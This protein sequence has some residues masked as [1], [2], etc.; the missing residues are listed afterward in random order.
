MD[1]WV[2]TP[3]DEIE[4]EV[5]WKYF[6]KNI[7]EVSFIST[8]WSG[9]SEVE[10]QGQCYAMMIINKF[11]RREEVLRFFESLEPKHCITDTSGF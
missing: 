11:L 3:D 2:N 8:A 7:S 5:D 10:W 9:T 4:R 6:S 1:T